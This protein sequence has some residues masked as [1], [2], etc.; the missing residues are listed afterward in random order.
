MNV[1]CDKKTFSYLQELEAPIVSLLFILL[2]VFKNKRNRNLYVGTLLNL[3]LVRFKYIWK[4]IS[5]KGVSFSH[6]I[7]Q[8]FYILVLCCFLGLYK[9]RIK[10]KEN[11]KLVPRRWL[12]H[13]QSSWKTLFVVSFLNCISHNYYLLSLV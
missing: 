4:E 9:V 8:V 10:E 5:N 3:L 1:E 6:I 11:R 12:Q 13:L 2:L 7:A